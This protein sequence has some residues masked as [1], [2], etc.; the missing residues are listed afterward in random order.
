MNQKN[1]PLKRGV[2]NIKKFFAQLAGWLSDSDN[3]NLLLAITVL[4]IGP[5]VASIFLREP[6]IIAISALLIAV[7]QL[8][9]ER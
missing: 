7:V 9:S 8:V 3:L 6:L 1:L 2:L 5:I 4:F